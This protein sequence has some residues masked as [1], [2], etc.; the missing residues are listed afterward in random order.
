[1]L[2]RRHVPPGIEGDT[3]LIQQP[4]FVR[5]REAHRDQHQ[6]GIEAERRAFDRPEI[7]RWSHVNGVE[8]RHIAAR[9]P[10]KVRRRDRPF[11]HPSFL[12]RGF[13]SH[14]ERPQWPGSACRT[15]QRRLGKNFQLVNGRC[16]LAMACPQTVGSR[17][18]T[19]ENDHPFARGENLSG[20][21]GRQFRHPPVLLGKEVNGEVDSFELPT[22]HRQIAWRLGA[23]AE[24]HRM[25]GLTQREGGNLDSDMGIRREYNSF[26]SQDIDPAVEHMLLEFEVGDAVSQQT[27]DTV[28]LLVD[29]DVVT[30]AVQLLCRRETGWA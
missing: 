18:A 25:I 24:Q 16:P 26:R 3:K 20:M 15:L 22:R 9:I 13:R 10:L 1:M 29:S 30:G 7:R 28:A 6:V 14:L 17:I 5:A 8:S 2:V 19:A 4:R 11:T 23:P 27:A 12:V 21:I